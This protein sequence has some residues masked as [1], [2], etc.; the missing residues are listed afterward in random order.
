MTIVI[1]LKR[2]RITYRI[3]KYIDIK[4]KCTIIDIKNGTGAN[5]KTVYRIIKYLFRKGLIYKDFTAEKK[6]DGAHFLILTTPILKVELNKIEKVVENFQ[7]GI[8]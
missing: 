1:N 5:L 6:K 7:N 4:G 8:N 3:Y 2:C